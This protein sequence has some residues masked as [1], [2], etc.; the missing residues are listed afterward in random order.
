LHRRDGRASL[1]GI[2]D[3]DVFGSPCVW[4]G[5]VPCT[6]GTALCEPLEYLKKG[7]KT[8]FPTFMA[9]GSYDVASC[10][11]AYAMPGPEL[12]VNYDCLQWA[13]EGCNW[14][15]DKNLCLGSRSGRQSA[16]LGFEVWGNPCVWCGGGVCNEQS[17]AICLP[18]NYIYN[19]QGTLFNVFHTPEVASFA[20]C[21]Q[22]G[23]SK[24]AHFLLGSHRKV[25]FIGEE[26]Q[27]SQFMTTGEQVWWVDFAT[28]TKHLV[29]P[30]MDCSACGCSGSLA[31][32]AATQLDA[33]PK[34]K[35]FECSLVPTTTAAPESPPMDESSAILDPGSDGKFLTRGKQVWWL[36]P[37][38]HRHLVK[39]GTDCSLCACQ[40]KVVFDPSAELEVLPEG[41]D[42][43]CTVFASRLAPS[44]PKASAPS[45]NTAS[46]GIAATHS[47]EREKMSPVLWW[48][49]AAVLAGILAVGIAICCCL[50]DGPIRR[51]K[52]KNKKK[53]RETTDEEMFES[54]SPQFSNQLGGSQDE[55][56]GS[57]E[58]GEQEVKA[59]QS[60]MPVYQ[61]PPQARQAQVTAGSYQPQ[62]HQQYYGGAVG[63][64]SVSHVAWAGA[65]P[66]AQP[67]YAYGSQQTIVGPQG[68]HPATTVFDRIDHN[69]DG[70]IT[71]EEWEK[72]AF[73][74]FDQNHDGR[75]SMDE[76][77]VGLL[78]GMQ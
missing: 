12:G 46:T 4:C 6:N 76:M 69:H 39:P 60:T 23:E 71:R 18:F 17:D 48:V 38:G 5:G 14:I 13:S 8:Y 77:R 37:D 24:A 72:Y 43:N 9:P 58:D 29:P 67:S 41:D 36:S 44:L 1:E 31:V 74:A 42:F 25:S 35:P 59:P 65:A 78:Q 53:A 70:S 47:Q 32:V 61:L 20:A 3:I 54:E 22:K 26:H 30:G 66:P 51:R 15:R 34:G 21:N 7:E 40:G 56:H 57:S 49:L 75:V 16:Y 55:S 64:Q 52:K 19:G 27:F 50:S 63:S 73:E 33:L 11:E 2:E 62:Q 68:N 45:A 10:D 28:E